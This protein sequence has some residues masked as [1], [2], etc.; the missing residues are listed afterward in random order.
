MVLLLI[1]RRAL[2]LRGSKSSY[3]VVDEPV[4]EVTTSKELLQVLTWTKTAML[5]RKD[6]KK[7]ETTE[8]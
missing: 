7:A 5:H 4:L 8:V 2:V 6:Q 3:G 1:L